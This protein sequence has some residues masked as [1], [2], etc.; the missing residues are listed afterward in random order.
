MVVAGCLQVDVWVVIRLGIQ[1][2]LV[3]ELGKAA[4]ENG[5]HRTPPT[6]TYLPPEELKSLLISLLSRFL[7]FFHASIL[8]FGL[9]SIA[10][11]LHFFEGIN[12]KSIFDLVTPY[13]QQKDPAIENFELSQYVSTKLLQTLLVKIP[14]TV[15][16]YEDGLISIE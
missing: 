11:I 15:D 16:T 12:P 6:S 4:K 13:Q 7:I 2:R 1:P 5:I 10:V 14:S 3:S 9:L 8:E